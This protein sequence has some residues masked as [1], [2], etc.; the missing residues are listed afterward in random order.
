MD[1]F[2]DAGSIPA[3]ST[4]KR[5]NADGIRAFSFFT[6]HAS[7]FTC[8]PLLRGSFRLGLK[9]PLLRKQLFELFFQLFLVL[10]ARKRQPRNHFGQPQLQQDFVN[11]LFC[12]CLGL[13][14]FPG[15]KV[16]VKGEE[17]SVFNP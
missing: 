13:L 1:F 5:P 16:A 2:S 15:G 7:L 4:I 17:L 6:I 14:V 10:T 11:L 9:R 12:L 3:I 8:S